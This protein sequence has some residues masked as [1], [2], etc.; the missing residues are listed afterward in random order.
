MNSFIISVDQGTSSTKT[1]VFDEK[2]QVFSRGLAPLKTEY[3][4]DG[5][6]EQDPEGIYQNVLASVRDCIKEFRDKGGQITDIKAC[7]ISNQRETFV[8]WDEAGRPLHNA[9]VWQCKR[10]IK[11]CERLKDQGMNEVVQSKTGLIIDPY[12]SGTKLLWLYENNA[13]VTTAVDE[14]RAYFGTVDSWLL[15]RLTNGQKYFTDYTNAS[16]TLFFN[17]AELKWDAELL[18]SFGLSRLKLPEPRPSSSYFGESDFDGIFELKIPIWSMIGDSHAA[19]FGEGCFSPGTAKATLGTGCSILMNVGELPPASG[20]GMIR[21]VCWSSKDRVDY[22]LEGVIVSCGATIEWIKNELG[23]IKDSME[24]EAIALSVDNN[25]GVYII[26]AFSGLGAPYWQMNRKASIAGLTFGANKNH[27]IRAALESIPYQIKDVIS[28][29]ESDTG[30]PLKELM[31]NGGI[32]KNKFVLQFLADLLEKNVVHMGMPD[33]SA[34]G[35]AYLAG[36]GI[37]LFESIDQLKMLNSRKE[38][39]TP[40][41]HPMVHRSYK[42]WLEAIA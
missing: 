18:N 11:I 41:A 23:L 12:F 6:V 26:P 9:I 14:G 27:I 7:G 40:A 36:L 1:L 31:V 20:S 3:F 37:G 33:V 8:I 17:L 15:F 32:T 4:G 19:A 29:M 28:A 13:A 2:G 24:T 39:N 21:T 10:S 35:A 22:A 16:R 30:I 42:G 25:N 34:L 5:F 38:V